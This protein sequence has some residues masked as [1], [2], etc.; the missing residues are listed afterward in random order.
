V[1]NADNRAI[2]KAWLEVQKSQIELERAGP[3]G[4]WVSDWLLEFGVKAGYFRRDVP[5]FGI[6]L[7]V[8]SLCYCYLS[9]AATMSN[10]HGYDMMRPEAR[11]A[12]LTDITR[13][14]MDS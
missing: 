6:H 9:N 12:W 10:F 11:D 4:C 14:V 7:T 8:V 13:I 3:S 1:T 2:V 5:L